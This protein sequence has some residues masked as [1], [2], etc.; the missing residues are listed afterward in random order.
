MTLVCAQ[1]VAQLFP[2]NEIS[3]MEISMHKLQGMK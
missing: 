2:K 3:H 1:K